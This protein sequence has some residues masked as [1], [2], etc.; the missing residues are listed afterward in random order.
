MAEWVTWPVVGLV[1]V[2]GIIV[3][4]LTVAIRVDLVELLRH[5]DEK[6]SKKRLEKAQAECDHVFSEIGW[7]DGLCCRCEKRVTQAWLKDQTRQG[8]KIEYI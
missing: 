5:R 8:K 4:C 1:G 2:A 7:G 6:N 3:T